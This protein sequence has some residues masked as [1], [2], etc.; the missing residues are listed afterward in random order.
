MELK[1]TG[2]DNIHRA[3]VNSILKYSQMK[4]KPAKAVFEKRKEAKEARERQ[5]NKDAEGIE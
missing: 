2:I 4:K 3:L 5:V 1:V